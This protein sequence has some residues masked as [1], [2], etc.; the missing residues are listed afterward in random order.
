M[1]SDVLQISNT[2]IN[3]NQPILWVTQEIDFQSFPP[4]VAGLV[5]MG[6]TSSPNFLDLAY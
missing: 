5:G 6:F 1:G 3:V 2:N 4:F